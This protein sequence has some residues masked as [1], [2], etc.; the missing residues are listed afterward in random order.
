MS[1]YQ[2]GRLSGWSACDL[3]QARASVTA[4]DGRQSHRPRSNVIILVTFMI[5]KTTSSY[6]Y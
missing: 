6:Y 5:S 3:C 1:T 2:V 4:C